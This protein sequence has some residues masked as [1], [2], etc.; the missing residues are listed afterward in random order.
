MYRSNDLDGVAPAEILDKKLDDLLPRNSKNPNFRP[1]IHNRLRN[2]FLWMDQGY[3]IVT[4]RDLLRYRRKEFILLPNLGKT[5]LQELDRILANLNLRMADTENEKPVYFGK[6]S[7]PHPIYEL[8][9]HEGLEI[10]STTTAIRVP[11]GWI[12]KIREVDGAVAA[13][14]VPAAVN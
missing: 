3:K 9:L 6:P 1:A 13:C 14:F 2:A 10:N 4:V 11:G 8:A 7:L 5:T 12:Y